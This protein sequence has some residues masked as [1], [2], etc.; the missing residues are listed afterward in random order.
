VSATG[1]K[2][3]REGDWE[4]HSYRFQSGERSIEGIRKYEMQVLPRPTYKKS[5]S[6]KGEMPVSWRKE[7][8][9]K[10]GSV[11]QEAG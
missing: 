9:D 11:S 7:G 2:S 10:K 3:I 6:D 8:G 4:K 5:L 1:R